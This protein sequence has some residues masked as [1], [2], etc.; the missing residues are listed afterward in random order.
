M[1]DEVQKPAVAVRLQRPVRPLA[2]RLEDAAHAWEKGLT[3]F[4]GDYMPGPEMLRE[5]KA[6]IEMLRKPL[7][8]HQIEMVMTQHY[9]LDSLLREN[10]DHFEACVRDIER[11]H[12]I[13][14]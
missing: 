3:I 1:T 7:T 12:G 8:R 9:P 13:G 4:G 2:E 10:L 6:E 14:A 11:L 5:A